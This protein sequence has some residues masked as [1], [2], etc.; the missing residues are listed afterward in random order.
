MR[1]AAGEAYCQLGDIQTANTRF[2]A[3]VNDYPHDPW[4][5][6]GWADAISNLFNVKT[7]KPD[8]QRALD[9]CA[10]ALKN[11]RD[12]HE[13]IEDRMAEIRKKMG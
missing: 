10:L 3:L 6:I 12:E 7:Y 9:I 13:C 2:Q 4:G 1:R 5:Y 11:C 8:Y